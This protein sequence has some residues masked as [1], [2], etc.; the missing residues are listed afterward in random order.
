MG[1]NPSSYESMALTTSPPSVLLTPSASLQSTRNVQ[2]TPA[3]PPLS[4]PPTAR[5]WRGLVAGVL[6]RMGGRF[7]GECDGE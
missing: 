7:E 2:Q 5:E 4:P 3:R 6:R 1:G